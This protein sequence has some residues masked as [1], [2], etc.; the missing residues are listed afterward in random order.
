M[1]AK[2]LECV[3]V[4]V[5]SVHRQRQGGTS[6]PPENLTSRFSSVLSYKILL[7]TKRTKIVAI[8][9]IPLAKI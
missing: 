6:P 4:A 9:H 5:V 7:C 2:Q 3:T 8:R 1:V